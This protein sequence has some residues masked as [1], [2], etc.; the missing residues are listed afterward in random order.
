MATTPLQDLFLIEGS[1][2][3]R[4]KSDQSEAWHVAECPECGGNQMAVLA[5]TYDRADDEA[6]WMRC[7]NCRRPLTQF[8]GYIQSVKRPLRDPQGITGTEAAAWSEVRSCLSVGAYTASV[9]LCRKLLFHIAVG[10]GL[11]AKND[12]NRAPTFAEAVDQLESEGVI[13]KKMRPWVDRIKDVGND[14][15]HEITPVPQSA[16]LDV[17]SFTLQLL[18]LAYELPTLMAVA[19][20]GLDIS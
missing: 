15:S 6:L 7:M 12:R 3:G 20:D 16:A 11:P 5:R 17:A 2:Y 18:V 14:A 8:R 4:L 10:H 9:M 13:T 1:P 19:E